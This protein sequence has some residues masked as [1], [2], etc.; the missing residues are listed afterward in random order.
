MIEFRC[1]HC[2]QKLRIAE[3][4]AGRKSRCP[5]CKGEVRIPHP[6]A[7]E[8]GAEQETDELTLIEPP[9]P[10]DEALLDVPDQQQVAAEHA[11]A[12]RQERAMLES[13]GI[14]T[15]P[16]YSGDR[17][18]PA[19]IDV[20]LYP[21]SAA[22]L[23]SMA[24]IGGYPLLAY[25]LQR[26]V[27]FNV[28]LLGLPFF[29]LGLGI[30]LYAGWYFAECVYDSAKGGTR[31][32][33]VFGG[34]ASW[35]EMWSRVLY[36]LAVY[37]VYVLPAIIYGVFLGRTDAAFWGLLAWAIVFFPMG[38]LAIVILDST[39]ALNPFFLLASILRTFF[40]Y[41]GLLILMAPLA[42]L[43]W[44]IPG[45]L[46]GGDEGQETSALLVIVGIA[47]TTYL[48]FVMAHLLGRF[49]W[50]HRNSLDWGL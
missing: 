19:P 12:H 17:R 2:H 22:G 44:L 48:P 47:S 24:I 49:Y 39:S 18:L 31:A 20:L 27:P 26:F 8:P 42:G 13:L 1:R 34:L 16:E 40:A 35:G 38:L 46:A 29:L 37:I 32:P 23:T 28:P 45:L 41:I 10:R 6:V 7:R 3:K 36:L 50:R 30:G 9:K 43:F 15:Q 5:R 14:E 11:E 25:L 4:H 21:T 33:L